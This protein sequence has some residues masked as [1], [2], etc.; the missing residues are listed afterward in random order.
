MNWTSFIK[1]KDKIQFLIIAAVTFAFTGLIKMQFL[2]WN[3]AR[4][5]SR[6]DDIIL[7]Q[8]DAK[9]LS[10]IISILTL[11]ALCAG[12]INIVQKPIILIYAL[13]TFTL[14]LIFRMVGMYFIPLEPP[15]DII[16]LRDVVLEAT[17]YSGNVLLKDLFF[18]GHTAHIF[19]MALLTDIQWLKRYLL[20]SGTIVALLLLIQHAHYTID[21][22]AAPIFSILAYKL[23]IRLTNK[24][25]TGKINMEHLRSGVLKEEFNISQF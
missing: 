6:L 13:N 2:I 20:I 12:F 3:E 18:S 23:N 16:P 1:S 22:L 9:D 4:R 21:V 17:F 7:N 24:W 8:I 5:G 25:L 15:H 10:L 19:L 11:A 14:I